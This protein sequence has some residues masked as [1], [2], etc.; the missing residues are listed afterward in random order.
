[1]MSK[2]SKPFRTSAKSPLAERIGALKQERAQ[3]EEEVLQLRAAVQ[4]WTAICRQTMTSAMQS[5]SF[6]AEMR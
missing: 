4:I 1:M 2:T 3:L 6:R 5:E